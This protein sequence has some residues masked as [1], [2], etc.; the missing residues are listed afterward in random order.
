M[1][2][3]SRGFPIPFLVTTEVPCPYLPD[4]QERKIITELGGGQAPE[5]FELLS[6]AGFRRSHGIAYRPACPGCQA[7]VPVR[8]PVRDFVWT[9]SL[10]RIWKRTADLTATVSENIPTQEQYD[11]FSRY[12]E[13]RHNDGEMVGMGPQ[14][15]GSMVADSPVDTRLVE[16]RD[17]ADRLIAC[18]LTDWGADGISAV[19]SFF[20]PTR[21][22]DSLG[23][24]IILWL[25]SEASRQ[26]LAY[27][28]LGYWVAGSRKMAYKARFQPMEAYG[29]DGWQRLPETGP[30][31]V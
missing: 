3:Y 13:A 20:D 2:V 31:G 28:Y 8:I 10:R 30:G 24:F 18:C 15:Y 16:F 12:L 21:A 7:C 19:Y 11:L 17:P 5:L 9:R 4:R 23:S 6:H 14:D 29:P 22:E 25:V 1:S 27:I 26:D